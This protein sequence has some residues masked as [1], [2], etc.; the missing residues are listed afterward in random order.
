MTQGLSAQEIEEFLDFLPSTALQVD[1]NECQAKNTGDLQEHHNLTNSYR[2]FNF[3]N[4]RRAGVKRLDR[5]AVYRVIGISSS[6]IS[7]KLCP[8]F[9][10][11]DS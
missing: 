10:L 8:G 3:G 5:F 11:M 6:N 2:Q 7:Q 4:T 1:N 9:S